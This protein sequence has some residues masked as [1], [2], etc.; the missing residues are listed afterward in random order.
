MAT[1]ITSGERE[2]LVRFVVDAARKAAQPAAEVAIDGSGL[3]HAAAQRVIERGGEFTEAVRAAVRMVV[4]DK[5]RELSIYGQ[6]AREVAAAPLAYPPE[7]TGSKPIHDQIATLTGHS[8]GLTVGP[9]E[10]VMARN[11][12][13]PDEGWF[14]Y[15]RRGKLAATYGEEVARLLEKIAETR[16]VHNYREG[17]LGERYLRQHARTAA[18]L[19]EAERRQQGD[20]IVLPVQ[21]GK[22]YAGSS[23]R[24]V[25]EC[26]ATTEFGL[27]ALSVGTM[28]LT[29]PEREVRWEQLHLDCPGDEGAPGADGRFV[30]ASG[31]HWRDGK[32]R[33]STVG[34]SSFSGDCGSVSARLPE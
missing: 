34:T 19:T 6:F 15:L 4:A 10:E 12:L 26:F 32:L 3:D 22:R 17:Q 5:L 20:V 8:P 18:M 7:Y 28:L 21:F 29:H 31:F 24:R 9:V 25:R 2:Q 33:F 14:A 11:T 16:T 1:S 30:S 27:G 23:V 13:L